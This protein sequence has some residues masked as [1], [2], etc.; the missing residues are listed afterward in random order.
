MAMT[1]T[2]KNKAILAALTAAALLGAT[3]PAS[4]R[5]WDR[6][7]R[8]SYRSYRAP[9]VYVAPRPVYYAAPAYYDYAPAASYYAPAPGYYGYGYGPD[10]AATTAVGAITGAVIGSQFGRGDGRVAG[11]AIGAILGG[12]IGN[13]V[14][15]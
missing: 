11:A 7:H 9:V 13:S 2:T 15:Y 14:G 10:R 4:A 6:D 1:P 8:H 5:D 3:A 12:V